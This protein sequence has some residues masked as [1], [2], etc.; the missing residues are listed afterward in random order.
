MYATDSMIEQL[1][2]NREDTCYFS[3]PGRKK[4]CS[5]CAYPDHLL[6]LNTDMELVRDPEFRKHVERYA[7]DQEVFCMFR[8]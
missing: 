1:E 8:T 6:M 4:P 2:L 5:S 3:P 7:Y